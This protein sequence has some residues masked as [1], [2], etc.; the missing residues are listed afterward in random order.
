MTEGFQLS[1]LLYSLGKQAG[2]IGFTCLSLLIISGDTARFFDRYFGL[3]KIIKFQRKFSLVTAF[4][5]VFHPLFFILSDSS[6]AAYLIPNFAVL[7]I[8]LGAISFYIFI[9]VIIA[10]HLYKRIS[11]AAWQYIHILIY[12]LFFFSLYHAFNLG[13]D[14]GLIYMRILYYVLL[15]GVIG[16]AIYRT[17]Y[18]IKKHYADRFYVKKIK[19]ETI[20]T[21]S[22]I[23][24]TPDNFSYKAGQFCFLRLNKNSLHARHPFTMSSSPKEQDMCFTIKNTGRFTKTAFNLKT[25][26]EIIIDGPFG[27][28]TLR[29]D[30][31]DCVFIAGGVGITPFFSIIKDNLSKKE[32][33]NIL[34]IYSSKTE[35]DIIFKDKLDNIKDKWFKKIHVLSHQTIPASSEYETGY[36]DGSLIKKYVRN[37]NNSSF[38][39]CGPS[40][41]KIG[42]R[43]ALFDLGVKRQNIIIE[44]F[45]W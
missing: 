27:I 22:L 20:N 14:S 13:S 28:F 36:I 45:F 44:D 34:L 39:I 5:I 16:G 24:K 29:D 21:F 11:Y 10:S 33:R 6:I 8:T 7:P 23:L 4:F 37:I 19:K 35:E 3:D 17:L 31:K 43:K 32:K 1:V 40:A 30:G 2:I 41:M 12:I 18:K 25:G 26:E 38:Y 42:V 15:L 9:I